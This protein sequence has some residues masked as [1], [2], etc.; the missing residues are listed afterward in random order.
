[1]CSIRLPIALILMIMANHVWIKYIT[2]VVVTAKIMHAVVMKF[3]RTLSRTPAI[4]FADPHA[5]VVDE[6][7]TT[8]WNRCLTIKRSIFLSI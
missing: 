6:D 8:V 1:M 2:P 5:V 3:F 4:S 7:T